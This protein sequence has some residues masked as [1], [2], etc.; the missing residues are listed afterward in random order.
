MLSKDIA[1]VVCGLVVATCAGRACA[2]DGMTWTTLDCPKAYGAYQAA[3]NAIDGSS[4]V[5]LYCVRSSSGPKAHGFLYD[6][7]TGTWKKLDYPGAVD[8]MPWGVSGNKIIGGYD[9]GDPNSAHV[10]LYDGTNWTTLDRPR[11]VNV[12]ALGASGGNSLVVY[13]QP[14]KPTH[15]FFY[16]G[17]VWTTLDYPGARWTQAEGISRDGSRIIGRYADSANSGRH[18]YGFCYDV[19]S[20]TWTAFSYPGADWTNPYGIDGANVVGFYTEKGSKAMRGFLYN[21]TTTAWTKLDHPDAFTAPGCGT[22]ASGI[23]GN[24]IVGRYTDTKYHDHAFVLTI[25]G[26]A[27]QPDP[28]GAGSARGGKQVSLSHRGE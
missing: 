21:L 11:A 13:S 15:G 18:A 24:H 20:G 26:L 1:S 16:N 23:S 2:G 5:G 6:L 14:S 19:A 4:I 9:S 10:F 7:A 12:I 25:P 3:A 22:F 8:T 27:A 28:A 17:K